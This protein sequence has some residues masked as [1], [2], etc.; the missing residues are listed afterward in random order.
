MSK[1]LIPKNE[2]NSGIKFAREVTKDAKK[3]LFTMSKDSFKAVVDAIVSI[4]IKKS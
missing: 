4:I 2:D 1:D 3:T